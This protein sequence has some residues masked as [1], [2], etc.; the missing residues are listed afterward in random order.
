MYIMCGIPLW[1]PKKREGKLE[2]TMV[3]STKNTFSW[4]S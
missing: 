1:I 4:L 3:F 2:K